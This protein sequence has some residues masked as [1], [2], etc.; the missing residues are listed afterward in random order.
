MKSKSGYNEHDYREPGALIHGMHVHWDAS[1]QV[2]HA[3]APH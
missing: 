2:Q 1:A 3:Y